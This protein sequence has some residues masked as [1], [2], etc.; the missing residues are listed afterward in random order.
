[1]RLVLVKHLSPLRHR[2]IYLSNSLEKRLPDGGD[3]WLLG[4]WEERR[5]GGVLGYRGLDGRGWGDDETL[6]T[7]TSV[8][9]RYRYR[10]VSLGPRVGARGSEPDIRQVLLM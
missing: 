5:V 3:V 7:Y 10:Q 6:D 2:F 4:S 9:R 8:I 1:M